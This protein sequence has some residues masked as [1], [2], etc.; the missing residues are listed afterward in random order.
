MRTLPT[1]L[2]LAV[3]ANPGGV[4]VRDARRSL[5]YRELDAWSTRLARLLIGRGIGPED[6]VAV[7][8]ERSVWSVAAVWAIAKAGAAFVPV[9]PNYPPGRVAHLVSDSGAVLGLSVRATVDRLPGDAW[10]VIDDPEFGAQLDAAGSE[11]VTHG[12]RVRPLQGAHPAYV[13][14]TSGST[15]LPKGV[16]VT[17]PGW[18]ISVPSSAIGMR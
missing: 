9:D 12:D 3:E 13:I 7:G 8:I 5:T 15:G 17:M 2:G 14:Y 1:L 4:A 16:V 6:L 11:P 10:L 18:R